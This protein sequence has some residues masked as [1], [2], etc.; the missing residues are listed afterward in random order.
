[1]AAEAEATPVIKSLDPLDIQ[2]LK[3]MV[4]K[5]EPMRPK[6]IAEALGEDGRRISAKM[7]KLLRLGLVEKVGERTYRATE[8]AKKAVEAASS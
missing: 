3:V 4:E 1:M 6:E 2:I 7:R 5:G 8:A